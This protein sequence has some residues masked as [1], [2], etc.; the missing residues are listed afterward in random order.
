MNATERARVSWG[1]PP[2]EWIAELAGACERQSQ[3]QVA[4][5][6]GYSAA[7]IS[8]ALSRT[9]R[10][11]MGRLEAAVRGALMHETVEC[12]VVGELGRDRCVRNQE[13]PKGPTADPV[14]RALRRT[15][16]ACANRRR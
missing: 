8:Q 4:R 16:P 7:V 10:G 5:Q 13:L 15:C 12:P 1:D 2:P 9:Y 6:L 14:R 3:G 11:D